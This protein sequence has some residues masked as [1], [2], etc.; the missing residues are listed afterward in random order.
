MCRLTAVWSMRSSSAALRMLAWRETTSKTLSG[1]S[2]GNFIDQ[3]PDGRDVLPCTIFNQISYS[4]N[5][6]LIP[7]V[8]QR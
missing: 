1:K 8:T 3:S 7:T 5:F 6:V 2:G 4:T